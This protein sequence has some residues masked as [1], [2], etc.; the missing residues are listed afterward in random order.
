[1]TYKVLDNGVERDA[2]PEEISE[3]EERAALA[4]D[5]AP[6][7][8]AQWEAIKHERDKR[9]AGGVKVVVDGVDKWFHSDDPSRI[10]QLGLVMMGAGIPA[11][12]QWKTMDGTF[13]TMTQTLAN[14]IF[15][16]VSSADQA[17]FTKAEQ[18]KAEMEA[19]VD[20]SAFVVEQ[21]EAKTKWPLVYGE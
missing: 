3:I 15:Q 6:K 17:I 20:P 7:R 10:Q 1:M 2:T 14:Q 4:S 19:L 8:A 13:V 5:P 21:D 9:K 16:A 18:L 12:L 11:N